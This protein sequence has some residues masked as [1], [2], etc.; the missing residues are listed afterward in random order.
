M[1]QTA[2][3]T[4]FTVSD[5]LNENQMDRGGGKFSKHTHAHTHTHTHTHTQTHTDYG[6][7]VL[8]FRPTC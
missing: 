6:T 5:L 7:K 4:A 1:L 3:V 2:R 8:R